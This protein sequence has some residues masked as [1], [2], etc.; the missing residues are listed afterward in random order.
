[1]YLIVEDAT[2]NGSSAI[3]LFG[4]TEIADTDGD[5]LN[6][7]IDAYRRPIRWIRW[8]SGYQGVVRAHPD[9]LDPNMFDRAT[10]TYRANDD[11][12]DRM[13]AD[14]GY[15]NALTSKVL[16]PDVGT[17]P[18]VASAGPDGLF[19]IRFELPPHLPEYGNDRR[20]PSIPMPE[21]DLGSSSGYSVMIPQYPGYS[22][23]KYGNRVSHSAGDVVF[24][25]DY[26]TILIADPWF[27]RPKAANITINDQPLFRFPDTQGSFNET[28]QDLRND[29][30]STYRLGGLMKSVPEGLNGDIFKKVGADD[31]TNYEITGAYQ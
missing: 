4:R 31:I 29:Y 12:F 13:R 30:P 14:P 1:L 26:G 21:P 18:L 17:T 3:E 25:T 11:Q 9:M 5:G 23:M 24:A 20:D 22:L 19:G 28:D 15:S 16:L 2:V 6:E 10:E 7:F 8:P 27:P